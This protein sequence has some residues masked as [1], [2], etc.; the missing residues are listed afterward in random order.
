MANREE[1]KKKD[2]GNPKEDAIE[3]I[4]EC[5]AVHHNARVCR[6]MF[7]RLGVKNVTPARVIRIEQHRRRHIE[8][9]AIGIIDSNATRLP[10]HHVVVH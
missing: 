3:V 9:H 6:N 2:S 5:P 10:F 8:V 4:A 1:E 7:F